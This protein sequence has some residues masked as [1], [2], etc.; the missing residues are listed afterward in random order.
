MAGPGLSGRG[1]AGIPPARDRDGGRERGW[2]RPPP[3]AS[4][5][6]LG[7]ALRRARRR[8]R[9]TAGLRH[10]GR[11]RHRPAR[12]GPPRLS[13]GVRGRDAAAASPDHTAPVTLT[14]LPSEV[15]SQV[16][17]TCPRA[18]VPT[19]PPTCHT[20]CHPVASSTAQW[21]SLPSFATVSHPPV[22]SGHGGAPSSHPAPSPTSRVAPSSNSSS[23]TPGAGWAWSLCLCTLCPGVSPGRR[24]S[25]PL[26][27]TG[28]RR[29]DFVQLLAQGLIPSSRG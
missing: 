19:V 4:S 1:A 24:T 9:G 5:A 13:A 6:P 3:A 15:P 26:F 7:S 14:H 28:Y 27:P 2:R 21:P 8:L 16:P 20:P 17:F 23:G 10:S 18:V 22:T 11:G 29:K 12:P 25:T